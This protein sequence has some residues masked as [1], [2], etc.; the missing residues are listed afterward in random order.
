MYLYHWKE[1]AGWPL[2]KVFSSFCVHRWFDSCWTKEHLWILSELHSHLT[3][4]PEGEEP[5]TNQPIQNE[6]WGHGVFTSAVIG[7]SPG[8]CNSRWVLYFHWNINNWC[9]QFPFF[10][11]HFS[12]RYKPSLEICASL[13]NIK[14]FSHIWIVQSNSKGH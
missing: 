1:H 4:L 2:K 14:Y 6:G 7:Q 5:H 12:L 9:S 3:N 8:A 13:N 10:F 11:M